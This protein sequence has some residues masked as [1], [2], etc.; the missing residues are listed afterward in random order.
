[1][2]VEFT[3]LDPHVRQFLTHQGNGTYSLKFVVPDVYGV[4]KYVLDYKHM[5][6]SYINVSA[7]P[8]PGLAASMMV[9][10][11]LHL[12]SPHAPPGPGASP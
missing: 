12:P 4:F 1:V 5:G 11:D 10:R 9:W 2:Q 3:M 7:R 8:G 6:Y